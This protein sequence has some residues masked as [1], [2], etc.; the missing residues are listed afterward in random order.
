MK[1][2][3]QGYNFIGVTERMQE[4]LVVLKLLPQLE[5]RD[6]LYLSA[7]GSGGFD[8]GASQNGCTYIIPSFVSP[9]MKKWLAA[10]SFQQRIAGDQLLYDATVQSLDATIDSLGREE[11]ERQVV[12]FR[13]ALK[14]AEEACFEKTRFPCSSDGKRQTIHDCIWWDSGCGYNCLDNLDI[15]ELDFY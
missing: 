7:K 8:D 14:K 2:I 11:V 10:P 4:S 3:L 6:I 13:S 1:T 9:G 15:P 12:I 5:L